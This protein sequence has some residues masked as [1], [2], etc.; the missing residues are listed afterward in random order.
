MTVI[1]ELRECRTCEQKITFHTGYRFEF[2]KGVYNSVAAYL[3]TF[4][5][6]D[7]AAPHAIIYESDNRLGEEEYRLDID[8]DIHITSKGEKGAFRATS[9][10]KQLMRQKTVFRQRIHDYP[11]I[12]N[13]GLMLDISRGKVPKLETLY[14]LAD[15][16]SD[17]KYNQLQLYMD[18]PVFEY[19]HY[20]AYCTDVISVQELKR[21]QQYCASRFIELVPNQNSFG[22]MSNW[23]KHSELAPLGITPDDGSRPNTLNPLDE[24]AVDFVDSL[25]SDLLPLHESDKVNIGMDETFSLGMGQTREACRTYGAETVYVEYLNKLISIAN[26]KYHKTPMFWDDMVIEKEKA[27]DKVDPESIVMVWGYEA[28][29]PYAGRCAFLKEKGRR[30]YT[31]PSTAT[32]GS[33]T[34]RFDNMIYN[35][36]SAAKACIAY[37]GEGL[38]MTEWGD[39]GHPQFLVM[40]FIP[41]IFA[42][43]C[44]WNY[45]PGR[46][47]T[48]K[49]HL[50]YDKSQDIIRH[51]E[52]YAD[53]FLFGAKG[54]GRL[55][56]KMANYY[57]VEN[58]NKWSGTYTLSEACALAAGKESYLDL[59][60]AS[61]I[62]QYMLAIKKELVQYAE[63]VPYLDD[64]KCNCDMVILFARFIQYKR[65]GENNELN[66][67]LRE[68]MIEVKERFLTL[69]CRN[70]RT[71][72][73]ELFVGV[74]ER[75]IGSLAEEQL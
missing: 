59:S 46:E 47:A 33:I 49:A 14:Q 64:I 35:V 36:E 23:L 21:F 20:E 22:H 24:R 72:G 45:N 27:F 70:N 25:Y 10:L 54:I 73:S 4:T 66:S 7:D 69:W 48:P 58:H 67:A 56:H 28:E 1:P 42:A 52:A 30:F 8:E 29:W 55:L 26:T 41:L 17:L 60:T 37:G 5:T 19:Q 50:A 32:F 6:Q 16:L 38:L 9:S 34:G 15:I 63:T 68:E 31:C 74:L 44:S 53:E 71:A 43:C 65:N 13:R 18:A 61:M 3:N 11:D 51:C 62:E 39:G 57:L 40:S 75:L 2:G 12:P